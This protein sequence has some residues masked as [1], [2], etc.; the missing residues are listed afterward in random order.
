[1]EQKR[2]MNYYQKHFMDRYFILQY[3]IKKIDNATKAEADNKI[4]IRVKDVHS[5][6]K[7]QGF[8]SH[9]YHHCYR[10]SKNY[11]II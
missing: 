6:L 9:I 2:C 4:D 10:S 11:K 8:L 3:S 1:M 7:S 5:S